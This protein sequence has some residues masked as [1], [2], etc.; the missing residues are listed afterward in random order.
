MSDD[1]RIR[2]AV[3][4]AVRRAR[5]AGVAVTLATG[6]AFHSALPFA[7]RLGI[8]R[9]LICYQGGLIKSPV[10]GTVLHEATFSRPLAHEL[11]VWVTARGQQPFRLPSGTHGAAEALNGWSFEPGKIEVAVFLGGAM[12]L[13]RLEQGI[14]FYHRYFGEHIRQVADLPASLHTA[15]TKSMLIAHPATCDEILPEL[16]A[17]FAGRLQIVRSHP[18]FVEA[19]PPGVSKGQGL[20]RLAAHLRIPQAATIAVG[21]N[22]NDLAMIEWAGL[23]VAMGNAT[24]EVKAAADWIAPTVA[25]DGVAA[26]VERFIC[27]GSMSTSIVPADHPEAIDR[28]VSVLRQGGLVAFPTDTVYGVG[29]HAF[30]PQA[31]AQLYEVK[32]RSRSKAIPLLLADVAGLVLVAEP[33][34]PLAERLAERFWPGPLTL[35]LPRRTVV[36]DVVTAG[37]HSVAVRVPDHSV[38]RALIAALGAPLATTSANRSG[39]PSPVTAE[40]VMAQLGGRID[41][42]LDGGACP[43]GVSSTV[44]DMTASPP[45]VLRLGPV[46]AEEIERM[47]VSRRG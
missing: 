16:K 10:D 14:E 33:I 6:R 22:E 29:A 19:V 38:A 5:A 4:E 2:P 1:L 42:I 15:P 31:V 25:E 13:E 23:G 17:A 43:G 40:E 12:Y 30:D 27:S 37:G 3:R 36:P 20:A 47:I 46:S 32:K 7:R 28:A 45:V 21:D 18:L 34:P 35:V 39:E 8:T 44:L 26:V 41:L 11:I 24:S 9:P